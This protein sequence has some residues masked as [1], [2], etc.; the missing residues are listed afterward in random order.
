MPSVS[1]F[2]E[3]Y[4]IKIRAIWYHNDC[5]SPTKMGNL[6]IIP[7]D[8]LGNTVAVGV[9][10]RWVTEG[11]W[12]Q[13]KDVMDAELSAQIEKRLITERVRVIKKQLIM[14]ENVIDK[15]YANIMERGFDSSASAVKALGDFIVEQRGLLQID[16]VI[17]ELTDKDTAT[18]Q[19][20]FRELA[21]RAGLTIMDG[22]IKK[23]DSAESID[24]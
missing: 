8:E 20:E 6:K 21:E 3:A 18:I 11:D 15:A 13:W 14:V 2:S 12:F 9:L 1:E 7:P 24:T 4:K 16:K 10:Q 19:R 22:E 17:E 5:P 23:E